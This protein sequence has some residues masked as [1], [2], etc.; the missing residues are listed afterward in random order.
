MTYRLLFRPQVP[1]TLAALPVKIR[2]R[3]AAHINE[4]P[5]SPRPHG[6]TKLAGRP[7]EYRIRVGDYRVVYSI[8][9]ATRTVE[10]KIIAHR[11]EVY[12]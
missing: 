6:C 8:D 7:E 9:D 3:V 10:I 11:R 12:R 4:L 5:A 1:K 2:Q